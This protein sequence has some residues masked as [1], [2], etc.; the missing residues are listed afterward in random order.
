[1]SDTAQ[2]PRTARVMRRESRLPPALVEVLRGASG[3]LTWR[4]LAAVAYEV[5]WTWQ[6]MGNALNCKWSR[7]R[8]AATSAPE[9]E[10]AAVRAAGVMV[11][12]TP[13]YPTLA[14]DEAAELAELQTVAVKARAGQPPDHPAQLAAKRFTALLHAH[15]Q[16][17]VPVA[18]LAAAAGVAES[19]IYLRFGRAG[20]GKL[21]PSQTYQARRDRRRNVPAEPDKLLRWAPLIDAFIAHLTTDA[22]LRPATVDSYAH[23]LRRF[24]L[25][26]PDLDPA[27]VTDDIV[28]AH[29]A[30]LRQQPKARERTGHFRRWLRWCAATGR[31][32]ATR[33]ATAHLR[34]PTGL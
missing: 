22:A 23:T 14:S 3:D 34:P 17:D 7:V 13:P 33:S 19:A 4:A 9:H 2:E 1:M 20:L 26:H 25:R 31:I 15:R 27:D 21:P 8:Y 29:V 32:D 6:G 18:V 28:D 11:P 12:F 5:G 24:A 16:R 30:L 10:K